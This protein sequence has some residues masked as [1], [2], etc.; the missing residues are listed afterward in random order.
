MI[1]ILKSLLKT[2]I[3]SKKTMIFFFF[4]CL[5]TILWLLN[6]LTKT[7]T[8]KILHPIV[9]QKFP[10]NTILINKPPSLLKMELTSIGFKL[11]NYK[12]ND[13]LSPILFP[14]SSFSLKKYKKSENKSFL[15]KNDYLEKIKTYFNND[16]KLEAI[17]L[18]TL[19]FDFE[20]IIH[21]KIAIKP[22]VKLNFKRQYILKEDVFTLPDSIIASAPVSFLDTLEYIYT[23]NKTF[24]NLARSIH[25]SIDLEK[26]NG[27]AFSQESVKLN[28][29]VEEFT[30]KTLNIPIKIINVPDDRKIKIFPNKVKITYLVGLSNFSAIKKE[31]F[32][33]IVDYNSIF[34]KKNILRRK[35]KVQISQIP[36]DLHSLKF[37]PKNV[38]Y[39]IEK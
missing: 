21:K 7:Y 24:D 35:I 33:L 18:D 31:H 13:N 15:V 25:T 32:K 36:D 4:L 12:W 5:S 28:V 39:I 9:Y 14:V 22:A 37:Y 29:V 11:I 34:G 30:E 19:F 16:V 6:A 3:N 8:I 23:K 1:K 10:K 17:F 38:E 27:I 2:K 26:I 20:P